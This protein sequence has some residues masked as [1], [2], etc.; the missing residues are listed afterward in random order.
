MAEHQSTGGTNDIGSGSVTLWGQGKLIQCASM[1]KTKT[2]E[3]A[4]L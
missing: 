1:N 3:V 2:T 4:Y